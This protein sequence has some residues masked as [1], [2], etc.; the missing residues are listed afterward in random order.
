VIGTALIDTAFP[1][2]PGSHKLTAIAPGKVGYEKL[3]TITGK[4][5][6]TLTIPLLQDAVVESPKEPETSTVGH[7]MFSAQLVLVSQ[8]L[9]FGHVFTVSSAQDSRKN[10]CATQMTSRC[11]DSG[12]SKIQTWDRCHTFSLDCQWLPSERSLPVRRG[13]GSKVGIGPATIAGGPAL[14]IAGASDATHCFWR[15]LQSFSWRLCQYGL[16]DTLCK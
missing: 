16:S 7:H 15:Q 6:E 8:E 9:L 10:D 1:V 4:S 2:D 11:D 12:V 13:D 5:E 3:L 14:Q